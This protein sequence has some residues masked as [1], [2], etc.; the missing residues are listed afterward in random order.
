LCALLLLL[1]FRS[2]RVMMI[3]M[4]VVAIS[5]VWSFGAMGFIGYHVTILMSVIAPLVIVTG[6]PNCV[7][8]INAYHYEYVRHGNKVKALQRVISRIGAAAFLTNATTAVGLHHVLLHLQ[9]HT[10]GIRVDRHHRHHGAMGPQLAMLIPDDLQLYA[11]TEPAP[12]E[13]IWSGAGWTAPWNGSCA[14][15]ATTPPLIYAVTTLVFVVALFGM[16]R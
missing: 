7:F 6:V 12:F 13:A 1:F 11:R 2:W 3:C 4:A 14:P 15:Y 8:L 10:E 16:L 5:V 9:P